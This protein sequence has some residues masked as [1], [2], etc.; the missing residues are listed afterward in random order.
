M[1]FSWTRSLWPIIR[2]ISVRY[3][4]VQLYSCTSP[5]RVPRGRCHTFSPCSASYWRACCM[6]TWQ[7][8]SCV[9]CC[10][11]LAFLVFRVIRP[12]IVFFFLLSDLV[13]CR[14][15]GTPAEFRRA[16]ARQLFPYLIFHSVA[17]LFCIASAR[18]FFFALRFFFP[19]CTPCTRRQTRKI[20]VGAKILLSRS[21]VRSHSGRCQISLHAPEAARNEFGKRN[22]SSALQG[23][24][25]H[26]NA[27]IAG[28]GHEPNTTA[29]L[30]Y[31]LE[32]I[33]IDSR[34]AWHW[35]WE[36][37]TCCRRGWVARGNV[38]R[39]SRALGSL[40]LWWIQKPTSKTGGGIG[41]SSHPSTYGLRMRIHLTLDRMVSS[42]N[43]SMALPESAMK[44][45]RLFQLIRRQHVREA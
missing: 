41:W 27:D 17:L 4:G 29:V 39:G 21:R 42:T 36:V 14:F 25:W 22:V 35:T 7:D 30:P 9:C 19:R 15:H 2:E 12:I 38:P 32:I 24:C 13:S 11:A 16:R 1:R 3:S 45:C 28:G 43:T 18:F 44:E 6:Y 34:S 5:L 26:R 20:R 8:M 33:W 40:S 37:S 31:T 10:C 23:L